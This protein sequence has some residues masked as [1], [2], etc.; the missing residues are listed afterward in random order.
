MQKI[1]KK[2]LKTLIHSIRICGQDIGMEFGKEKCAMQ[3]MKS[4]ER[5]FTD[6]MERPNQDKIRTLEEKE[7]NKYLMI[8]EAGTPKQEET[9][10]KK[11]RN[12]ISGEPESYLRQSYIAETLS[13]E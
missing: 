1:K 7:T 11:L 12:N 3:V 9:K 13:K 6:G 5:H 10:E 4:G 8:L 2:E